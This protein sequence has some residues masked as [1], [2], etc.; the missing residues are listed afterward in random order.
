MA[1]TPIAVDA[2]RFCDEQVLYMVLVM[3]NESK[4]DKETGCVR[5]T[6]MVISHGK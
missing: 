1:R 2:L 4:K 6:K 3:W 5:T